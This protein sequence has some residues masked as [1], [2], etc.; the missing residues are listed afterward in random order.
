MNITL[1]EKVNK[2][3]LRQVQECNNIPF[4]KGD[5]PMWIEQIKKGL[6]TYSKKG[7][8]KGKGIKTDYEQSNKYGRFNTKFGLQ[9]LQRE[10][11]KYISGEY[12]LDLDFQNCHPVIL[13]QLLKNNN[14]KITST[15]CVRSDG[16]SLLEEYINNREEYLEKNRLTKTD[17]ICMINNEENTKDYFTDIH[18]Q[19]YK[20][21]YPQLLKDNKQLFAR[22]KSERTKK[23]KAYNLKG[24]FISHY[25]QNIENN[26][27]QVLY[28]YLNEKGYIVGALMFDGLM[29]EKVN[30]LNPLELEIPTIEALIKEQTGYP[31]KIKFKSTETDWVPIKA[32]KVELEVELI[33]SEKYS[34]QY[35]KQ[36]H[37]ACFFIDDKGKK[38]VV[39][40][41]VPILINYI[42][43]YACIINT[44]YG[45]GWR[46]NVN[47]L[48]DIRSKEKVK[49]RIRFGFENQ[50]YSDASW[51]DSD[52]ALQYN[53]IVFEVNEKK[54]N[55]EDYNLYKRPS[56]KNTSKSLEEIS[57]KLCDFFK[58]VLSSGDNQVYIWLINYISKMSQVG[59]TGQ[60]LV[61]QGEMGTGKSSVPEIISWII[62]INYYQK[63]DDINQIANNFNALYE[64][65]IL[66][67]CE[68]IIA[69][70][71]DYHSI[72]SK[73]KTLT[74]ESSIKIER[75][76]IDSYMSISMNNFILMT[77]EY[78]PV[79]AT[80]DNRR[81]MILKVSNIVQKNYAYFS[82]LK[83]EVKDNIEEIRGFFNNYKYEDNLNNIRPTTE[84]ELEL[85]ILNQS[86]AD[87]F[88]KD[89]DLGPEKS[90]KRRYAFVYDKYKNY[91]RE[92]NYKCIS[93]KYFTIELRNNDYNTK[94]IGKDK[95]TYITGNITDTNDNEIDI[96][97]DIDE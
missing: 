35:N 6:N 57:P 71:G 80:K 1:Y 66:T 91:C 81:N 37:D 93:A 23:K 8:N 25:L 97:T 26:C 19:I 42:N 92:N 61:L 76:G 4:E 7:D 38:H 46:N 29:V 74:T 17:M 51:C 95:T 47:D 89:L 54:V 44:P 83:N 12:Y 24:A 41:N 73:L 22:I 2:D 27:L 43:K 33:E 79:K 18:N 85:I 50:L 53:R 48:F 64:K 14:A 11:R 94:K 30:E 86:S 67:S 82:S 32:E 28:K 59:M 20:E 55:K 63:V 65:T 75:K 34:K 15:D 21:L 68:E 39:V 87:S 70:A 9:T 88:I 58:R 40:E 72:Q 31:L 45:Y 56:Y 62:G 84:A 49:D 77:N 36:L 16:K 52:L 78:N 96:N 13:N 69:N 90:S 3:K 5:D 60:L 10:L